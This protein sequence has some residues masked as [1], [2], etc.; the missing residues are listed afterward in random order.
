[1]AGTPKMFPPI[2]S[3][4]RNERP[5]AGVGRTVTERRVKR[6]WD[7]AE[8]V[9]V[10]GGFA[11][12][13]DA[14]PLCTPAKAALLVPT[15]ALARALADEWAAQ[16]GEVDPGSMPV[17]GSA[18]AAIDRVAGQFD[19]VAALIAD[20]GASDLICY[21][22]AH[23][24]GIVQLQAQAWDPLI[25]WAAKDLGAPLTPVSGVVH[26]P[27]PTTSLG[28]LAT[29]VHSC[30]VFELTALY[31]LVSL[32]GSLVIG[33]A[34]ARRAFATDDLWDRSQVDEAWQTDQWG[35]DNEARK[36]TESRRAA[37]LHADRFLALAA[38]R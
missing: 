20:Y 32:S 37:F 3:R 33:L 2:R 14:R 34:A 29:L 17:T 12:H 25:D 36:R 27:Q 8:A 1:M 19:E 5:R 30:D 38:I 35:E 7:R 28:A 31:D 23:P 4:F 26:M 16:E 9:K 6:F 10:A 22:A 21:R 15:R 11:V 13:L 24:D 18:N